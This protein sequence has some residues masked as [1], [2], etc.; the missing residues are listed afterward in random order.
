M[1]TVLIN[2]EIN[3]N[4]NE[5]ITISLS[6]DKEICNVRVYTNNPEKFNPEINKDVYGGTQ[7]ESIKNGYKVYAALVR[8]YTKEYFNL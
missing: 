5:P 6:I 8:K 7:K 1:T 3:R 2:T 4:G